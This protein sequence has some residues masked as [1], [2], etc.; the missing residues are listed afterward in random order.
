M[1][2]MTDP[3]HW[4]LVVKV[5]PLGEQSFL[6]WLCCS[7]YSTE[8][9]IHSWLGTCSDT[10]TAPQLGA[11]R[12]RWVRIELSITWLVSTGPL[13]N[14]M[15]CRGTLNRASAS[16]CMFYNIIVAMVFVYSQ[17]NQLDTLYIHIIILLLYI[18]VHVPHPTV[19]TLFREPQA[20]SITF[21]TPQYLVRHT[22]IIWYSSAKGRAILVPSLEN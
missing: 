19:S 4:R 17:L 9:Q 1:W 8:R 12:V 14:L 7:I 13:M 3:H 5:G 20:Q 15:T 10:Q 16:Y 18:H 6:C 11:T 2:S 21:A 22:P